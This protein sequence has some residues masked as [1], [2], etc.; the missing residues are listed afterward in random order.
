MPLLATA[1]LSGQEQPQVP[2]PVQPTAQEPNAQ[3]Q[4][5]Q[6]AVPVTVGGIVRNAATGEPLPRALVQIEGDADTAALTDTQGRFELPGVPAG[7]QTMRVRKPGYADRPYA[8]EDVGFEGAGPAHNVLVAAQM[9]DLDFALTPNSAIFGRVELATGDPGQGISL[10]L[11]KQVVRNGRAVWAQNGIART[12]GEGAY[13]FSGLP[14]GVYVLSTQPSLESDPA[15]TAVAPG[16]KV[17]REGY[18]SVFYPGAREFSGATRI[19][20]TDGQQAEANLLLTPEP[21]YTVTATAILPNGRV[22]DGNGSEQSITSSGQALAAALLNSA[23]SQLAYTTQFDPKNGSIQANL[24]YGTY[25]LFVAAMDSGESHLDKNEKS[26]GKV[27]SPEGFQGFAEFSVDS[28]ALDNL[29]VPLFPQINWPIQLRVVRTNT[30][31]VQIEANQGL[32]NL[33]TVTVMMAG[34]APMSHDGTDSISQPS[35]PELLE[36]G[37]P[38]FG[39][40]WISTQVDD[41][42]LCVDSFTAGTINLA[43]EPLNVALGAS[44]PPMELTLRDDCAKLTLDLPPALSE[45]LPGDEPFYTVYIVPDFDTTVDIPPMNLHA[46]SGASLTVDG[47]APGS[48]HV[49]VFDEPVHLEYRNPDAIAALPKPGQAVTLTAGETSELVLEVPER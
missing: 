38:P 37:G 41:R 9:P 27:A 35:G 19:R 34:D 10:T 39:P 36:M 43:R 49:Y 28:H 11:L 3:P 44:P 12:N 42:S 8:T 33:A 23:N 30:S 21:F 22:F 20:L 48:Y 14:S 1:L 16:A 40:H 2:Q 4:G 15:V 5:G 45:F 26:I 13:R 47:L 17:A 6:E 31:P 29:T 25:T 32:Q 46:S 18:A 24:P 7:P